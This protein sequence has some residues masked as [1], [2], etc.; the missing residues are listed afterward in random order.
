MLKKVDLVLVRDK[1]SQNFLKKLGVYSIL[2]TDPAWC[3]EISTTEDNLLKVDKINLGVQLR[4]WKNSYK[5]E[6]KHYCGY[7]M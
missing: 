4:E 2:G 3:L 5:Q 1:E 7:Y 6:F